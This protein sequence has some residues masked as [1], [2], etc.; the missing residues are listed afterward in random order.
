MPINCCYVID[1]FL[2]SDETDTLDSVL[3]IE[4]TSDSPASLSQHAAVR[5]LYTSENDH[6]IQ[7]L[8]QQGRVSTFSMSWNSHN[9]APQSSDWPILE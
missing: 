5:S 6:I 9:G 3:M 7:I 4:R 2:W 8:Q 1:L